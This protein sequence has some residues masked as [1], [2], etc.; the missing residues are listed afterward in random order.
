MISKGGKYSLSPRNA[1]DLVTQSFHPKAKGQVEKGYW[2]DKLRPRLFMDDLAKHLNITDLSGWYKITWAT[3]RQHG[4]SRLLSK[5]NNSPFQLL[6]AVYTQYPMCNMYDILFITRYNWDITKFTQVQ[7]GY[8]NSVANQRLFMDSIA[9][10]LNITNV[11]GWSY[12]TSTSVQQYGGATLLQ[13]YK[14]SLSKLLVSVYP[15]Y[16][17]FCRDC[18]M[19]MVQDLKLSKPDDL[20]HV[21]TEYLQSLY[22]LISISVVKRYLPQL[23]PQYDHSIKKCMKLLCLHI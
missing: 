3:L 1:N 21:P 17:Q 7:R 23:L 20:V 16:K 18:A 4:G 14:G 11:S 12:I 6:R 9:S 10:Q 19:I 8:W 2:D 13:K 5:F 22:K 15:E